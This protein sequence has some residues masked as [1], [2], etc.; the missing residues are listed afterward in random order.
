MV[1]IGCFA[2]CRRY[3]QRD[4]AAIARRRKQ[5]ELIERG[6][7]TGIGNRYRVVA[8]VEFLTLVVEDLGAVRD[9]RD[10]DGECQRRRG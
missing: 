10:S 2:R 4:I 1:A 6:K 5:R 9:R 3:R 7:P 8:N